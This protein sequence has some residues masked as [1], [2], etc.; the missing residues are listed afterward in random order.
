MTRLPVAPGD[1]FH[2]VALSRHLD[3]DALRQNRSALAVALG[4]ALGSAA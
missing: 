3:A 2:A 1:P 4:L